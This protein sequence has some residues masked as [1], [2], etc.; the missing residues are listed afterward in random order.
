MIENK[1]GLVP[2]G[3]AVLIKPYVPERKNALLVLPEGVRDRAA[4]MEHRATVVAIGPEAW[5]TESCPRAV[6][7]DKVLV[8]KYAGFMAL[9]PADGDIYRLVNDQDLFCRI[10]GEQDG[11]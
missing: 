11:E 7:G 3:H 2:V 1:S 8:T 9:G 4:M 6:V 10:E 5:R